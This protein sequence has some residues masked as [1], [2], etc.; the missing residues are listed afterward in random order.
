M[1]A[2]SSDE[3]K[4]IDLDDDIGDPDFA[5]KASAGD[6]TKGKLLHTTSIAYL[7]ATVPIA[8]LLTLII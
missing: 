6:K 2:D 4:D 7:T 1:M 5:P 8:Y 3:E